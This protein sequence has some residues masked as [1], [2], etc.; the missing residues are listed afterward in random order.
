MQPIFALIDANNFYASC[1]KVFDPKLTD[2]PVVVL[3]NND[4]CIV[5]RSAESKSLGIPMG[6]PIHEWRDFCTE[7]GVVIKSSN[8]T[9]YGDMSARMLSV[10][11]DNCPEVEAYSIDESFADLTGIAH[12]T[13]LG[14]HL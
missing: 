6:A 7:H 10:I 14:H 12:A 8:Y 2:R 4:G 11:Q 13:A 3:S 1:E 5:A 9:L